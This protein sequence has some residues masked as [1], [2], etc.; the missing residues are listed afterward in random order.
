MAFEIDLLPVGNG[1]KSGDAILLRYGDLGRGGDKQVVIL[2]DGGYEDTTDIIKLHL[3]QYYNC[4]STDGKY[5]IDLAILSHP[6][7]DHVSGLAKLAEDDEIQINNILMQ[8]PWDEL[9]PSLFADGRITNASLKRRLQDMFSKAYKLHC[10]TTTCNSLS[11]E[12]RFIDCLL[13]ASIT[14]LGPSKESYRDLIAECDK[15]P[16]SASGINETYSSTS[17]EEEED[18]Y[19][20]QEIEWDDNEKTSLIN[21]SS[22][23]I[24]F[25]YKDTDGKNHKI[26]FTGDAG[27]R[28]LTEA[29]QYADENDISLKDIEI[30]KMPHH[31]SRKNVSPEIM[32]CLFSQGTTCYISCSGKDE[33]HHPSKRLVNML[34]QKGYRVLPNSGSI[35]HRG[36]NAPE[37][38]GY[39]KAKEKSY[40]P[41]MEKL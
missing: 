25:E 40:Y 27:K 23:I 37:R 38:V 7:N 29:I 1:T 35:L 22:L 8:R 13:G 32:E 11:F 31:G 15:T 16:Q 17:I 30:I 20:G 9:E 41:K 34:I 10:A 12:T 4:R 5:V 39:K 28:G 3:Q 24:L 2:I 36:H 33:G 26:L 18:F 19:E 21:E 14:I 6:D